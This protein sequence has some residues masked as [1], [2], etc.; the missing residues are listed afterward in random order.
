LPVCTEF[1]F[2]L[3][4]HIESSDRRLVFVSVLD[5]GHEESLAVRHHEARHPLSGPDHILC[6]TNPEEGLPWQCR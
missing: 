2:F 3:Q 5:F 4:L 6:Y 1:R